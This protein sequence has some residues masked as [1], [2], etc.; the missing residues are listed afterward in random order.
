M[1]AYSKILIQQMAFSCCISGSMKWKYG[2]ITAKSNVFNM[3]CVVVLLYKLKSYFTGKNIFTIHFVLFLIWVL[4]PVKI[5]SLILSRIN[6]KVGQKWEIPREKTLDHLQAELGLPHIWLE[7]QQWD[8]DQFKVLKISILNHS[9]TGAAHFW[10][11]LKASLDDSEF[12]LTPNTEYFTPSFCLW[13]Q[14][15][16]KSQQKN[17]VK[18][19]HFLED[20][21]FT[22]FQ[23]PSENSWYSFIQDNSINFAYHKFLGY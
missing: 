5:I 9:A 23:N 10:F 7:P 19:Q 6:R 17:I 20:S 13:L 3:M 15:F 16:A 22:Y 11:N 14:F 21:I 1:Y 4:W 18:L 12:L 8:D 2:T